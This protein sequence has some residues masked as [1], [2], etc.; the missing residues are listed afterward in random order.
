L[1]TNAFNDGCVNFRIITLPL[2][3]GIVRMKMNNRRTFMGTGDSLLDNLIR[4]NRNR[5]LS[6]A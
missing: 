1:A 6:L 2:R 3:E 4:M 5:R